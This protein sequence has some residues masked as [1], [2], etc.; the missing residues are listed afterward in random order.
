MSIKSNVN[1]NISVQTNILDSRGQY[2]RDVTLEQQTVAGSAAAPAI[3]LESEAATTEAGGILRG[4]AFV[5]PATTANEN[6]QVTTITYPANHGWTAGTQIVEVHQSPTTNTG[7]LGDTNQ[8]GVIAGTISSAT[9]IIVNR[10]VASKSLQADAG[11]KRLAAALV[12]LR[13]I[14]RFTT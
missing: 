13:V 1:N 14:D 7:A 5:L 3:S 4:M 6:T 2:P 12:E 8:L 9:A 11:T 10:S